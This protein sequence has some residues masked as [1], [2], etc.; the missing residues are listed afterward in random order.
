MNGTN[1]GWAPSL[2]IPPQHPSVPSF[3]SSSLSF[4]AHYVRGRL[5]HFAGLLALVVG[6]MACSI[7][8][9]VGMKLLVDAMAGPQR[10]SAAV[11]APLALFIGLIAIENGLWRTGG[12]L[13]CRTIVGVGVDVRLDLFEYLTGHPM[14]YFADHFAGSLGNRITSTAGAVGALI[15]TLSWN[16]VPPCTDF[17]GAVIIFTTIDWRMA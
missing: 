16:I 6:A 9:Q 2:E 3:L 11:W 17:I 14:R 5:W 8:V 4:L 15:S 10:N 1:R 13:G 7:G 12:W